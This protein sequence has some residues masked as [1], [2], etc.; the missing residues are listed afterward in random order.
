[1]KP[2]DM[3]FCKSETRAFTDAELEANYTDTMALSPDSLPG[4]N[5]RTDSLL[6]A[7]YMARHINELK[8][9]KIVP[10]HPSTGADS[11]TIRAYVD[12][13]NTL[14]S[15]AQA[16]YCYYS[17]RYKYAISKLFSQIADATAGSTSS[18]QLINTQTERAIRLNR[19]LTDLTQLVNAIT[20]DAYTTAKTLDNQINNLNGQLSEQ[21]GKLQRQASILKSE[22]PAVEIK[23][24]MVEYTREKAKSQDNLLSLY[25]FLDIVALGILFYVYKAA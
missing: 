8:T 24:R 7:S 4:Q 11:E 25:F 18:E 23:K 22:A 14:N 13:L 2:L 5:D 12:A 1:M 16:E 19:R 3:A 10:A 17:A 9:K 6:S 15:N 21:F 20:V